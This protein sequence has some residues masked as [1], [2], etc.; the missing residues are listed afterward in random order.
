MK[1]RKIPIST[2]VSVRTFDFLWGDPL[3]LPVVLGK[4]FSHLASA[5][6]LDAD[7]ENLLHD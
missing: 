7:E 2:K 1:R 5:S 3:T 6:V 4:G